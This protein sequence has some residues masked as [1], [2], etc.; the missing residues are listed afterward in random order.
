MWRKSG[1]GRATNATGSYIDI[2]SIEVCCKISYRTMCS[3]VRYSTC[4]YESTYLSSNNSFTPRQR[5]RRVSRLHSHPARCAGAT[6]CSCC[7][8]LF[9]F[10][11]RPTT[12][13]THPARPA[14]A[15]HLN[16][17]AREREYSMQMHPCILKVIIEANI[18]L[19][20]V[21]DGTQNQ[22][23]TGCSL[24]LFHR[25]HINRP[26]LLSHCVVVVV[27][28]NSIWTSQSNCITPPKKCTINAAPW[29]ETN[30]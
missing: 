14:E 2:E 24:F 28:Y 5:A 9:S 19:T 10:S 20:R 15:M 18:L 17:R 27:V 16:L 6:G 7:V 11:F 13:S 22:Y 29:N 21:S 30:E 4:R 3:Y 25:M 23:P 26:R 8:L 12:P 1:N